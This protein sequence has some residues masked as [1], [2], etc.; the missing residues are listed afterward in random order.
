LLHVVRAFVNKARCKTDRKLLK[1][2]VGRSYVDVELN[3]DYNWRRDA[4]GT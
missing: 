4:K 1:R 3:I 2:H